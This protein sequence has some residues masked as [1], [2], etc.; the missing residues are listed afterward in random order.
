MGNRAEQSLPSSTGI[1][2]SYAFIRPY[3]FTACTKR[4]LSVWCGYSTHLSSSQH[5]MNAIMKSSNTYMAM[6]ITGKCLEI[7]LLWVVC[8]QHTPP[9]STYVS[10]C[11]SPLLLYLFLPQSKKGISRKSHTDQKTKTSYHFIIFGKKLLWCHGIWWE[12]MPFWHCLQHF[13]IYIIWQRKYSGFIRRH[14]WTD[15]NNFNYRHIIAVEEVH[16]V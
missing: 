5:M 6:A 15:K 11:P 1:V 2:C 7:E 4:C 14:L 3:P 13:L 8:A 9:A 12:W 16:R 10:S